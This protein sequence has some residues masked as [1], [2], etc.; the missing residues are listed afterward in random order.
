MDHH[1]DPTGEIIKAI[2]A[3]LCAMIIIIAVFTVIFAF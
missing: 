3:G 2:A 1:S